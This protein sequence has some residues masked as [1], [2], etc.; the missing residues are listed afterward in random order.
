MAE[1]ME[2][3]FG[4]RTWVPKE[5]WVRW[6]PYL[7]T[8][9]GNFEG[10]GASHCKVYGLSSMSCAKMAEPI[11]LPFWVWTQVSSRKR[12]LDWVHVATTW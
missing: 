1:P 6:G 10:K 8:Y 7:P 12:A 5:A 4:L 9:K 2:L 11:Q 3:P